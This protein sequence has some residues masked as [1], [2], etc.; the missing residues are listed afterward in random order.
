MS[1]INFIFGSSP[2]GTSVFIHNRTT[3]I[4]AVEVRQEGDST[5]TEGPTARWTRGATVVASGRRERVVRFNRN[6][7]ITRGQ[8]FLFTALVSAQGQSIE[9]RQRLI[10]TRFSSKLAQSIANEPW[11]SDRRTRQVTWWRESPGGGRSSLAIIRY[12]AFFTGGF[13]DI[14]YVFDDS[15]G[16]ISGPGLMPDSDRE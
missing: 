14:E 4:M 8:T 9:L 6:R 15:V 5:L 3:L 1:G 7:G 13:D 10:G 12:R 11:H 2:S 16:A